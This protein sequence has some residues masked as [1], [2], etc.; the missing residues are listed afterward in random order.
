M[1]HALEVRIEGIEEAVTEAPEEEER[2]DKGEWEDGLAQCQL[3]RLCARRHVRL[4]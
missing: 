2:C 4:Y 1:Q 3:G